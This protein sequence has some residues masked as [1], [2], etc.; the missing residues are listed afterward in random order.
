MRAAAAAAM[1]P[2]AFSRYL[3]RRHRPPSPRSIADYVFGDDER[4]FSDVFASD[5]AS[6]Y[7]FSIR[8]PVSVLAGAWR[9]SGVSGETSRPSLPFPPLP[10][11]EQAPAP[12]SPSTRRPS[13]L[14]ASPCTSPAPA[15]AAPPSSSATR[16]STS[17]IVR[18]G[19]EGGDVVDP[20][21]NQ[22]PF[23]SPVGTVAVSENGAF[24]GEAVLLPL[25]PGEWGLVAYAKDTRIV[26][27]AEPV[28]VTPLRPHRTLRRDASGAET[29]DPA[30]AVRLQRAYYR[31]V[32]RRYEVA[33]RSA[34]DAE[35][36]R[37]ERKS[38][39]FCVTTSPSAR[40]PSSSRG[41]SGWTAASRRPS[42]TA[43]ASPSARAKSASSSCAS[44]RCAPRTRA[45]DSDQLPT[46]H[47]L[48]PQ[49]LF[50]RA[51]FG[52]RLCE[53]FAATFCGCLRASPQSPGDG[54][55]AADAG[56]LP[57]G[58]PGAAVAVAPPPHRPGGGGGG[59]ALFL[60]PTSAAPQA[61]PAAP[62]Q[63]PAPPTKEAPAFPLTS[64]P[65]DKG[66]PAVAV[67]AVVP[68][69]TAPPA[70]DDAKGPPSGE[71]RRGVARG[72]ST[73]LADAALPAVPPHPP[74]GE[75]ADPAAPRL[76]PTEEP[77][78]AAGAGARSAR[79]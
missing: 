11:S 70:D 1:C 53:C 27:S 2:T 19:G 14:R 60:L 68:A 26:I 41:P 48:P 49:E 75:V 57:P 52:A 72:L 4:A 54:S 39:W 38:Q 65:L 51:T 42:P 3:P 36:V 18:R 33:N 17:S 7:T 32:E 9:R 24:V 78:D 40:A 71:P 28:K 37:K 79:S 21:L 50:T 46:A 13:P 15:R 44:G 73:I 61:A 16:S 56:S 30:R 20:G 23:T 69:A 5:T 31:V 59:S 77:E 67:P 34:R 47:P 25:R 8:S 29:T 12:C 63:A 64:F 10:Y 6:L 62:P 76:L 22:P 55:E 74:R 66:A 43:S 58:L 35:Q 45:A